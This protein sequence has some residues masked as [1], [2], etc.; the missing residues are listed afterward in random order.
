MRSVVD[1][2]T[3]FAGGDNVSCASFG[4]GNREREAELTELIP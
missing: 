4:S 2:R 1:W 3:R